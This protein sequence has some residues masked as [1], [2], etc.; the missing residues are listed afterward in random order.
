MRD[1]PGGGIEVAGDSRAIF[2]NARHETECARTPSE[3]AG[4]TAIRQWRKRP[5]AR[6]L[7]EFSRRIVFLQS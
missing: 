7:Q 1:G 2:V 6:L 4:Y 5:V 3:A